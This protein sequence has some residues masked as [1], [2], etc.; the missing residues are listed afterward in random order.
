MLRKGFFCLVSIL[1]VSGTAHATLAPGTTIQDYLPQIS[2]KVPSAG[3]AG[4]NHAIQN[5]NGFSK[6]QGLPF[7]W[8]GQMSWNTGS[9]IIGITKL[10][11][12]PDPYVLCNQIFYNNT[13]NTQTYQATITQPAYLSSLS[14]Q[15]YGSIVVSLQDSDDPI[16]GSMLSDNNTP[17]YKA[18]I[19]GVL[20]DTLLD[21]SYSLM[22]SPPNNTIGSG[23]REFG[24]NPYTGAVNNNISIT[25][26]LN[27]SPGDTATV[28]SRFDVKVIPEPS[29]MLLVGFGGLLLRRRHSR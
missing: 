5:L 28:L 20:V 15:V 16:N 8:Q 10:E 27:L 19:D 22:T 7:S 4:F 21:P 29:M 23:L 18:F 13:A 3:I 12:D 6:A 9:G 26:E 2:G 24:W 25:V 14:N 17:I 11:F 1:F